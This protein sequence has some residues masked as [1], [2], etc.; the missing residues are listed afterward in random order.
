[1]VGTLFIVSTPIGNLEDITFRAIRT[2]KDASTIAAEDTR[3]T[4]KLCTHYGIGTPL[5]SYHDF[6][7]EEK[8]PVFLQRLQEG[9][10]IALVSDAGTPLISDPGFFLVREALAAKIP[11]VP[12]PGPSAVL[13]ALVAS[14]FPPDAFTFEGFV[15]RKS[16]ARLQLFKRLDNEG[17][18]TILF[19]TPHR[20]RSTLEVLQE[21]MGDRTLVV[22]RELTKLHEEILRGTAQEL[23][24]SKL[25]KG[26]KGEVTI[27]IEGKPGKKRKASQSQP[28]EC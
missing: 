10:H 5:T 15:P 4:K 25:T 27:V 24:E 26:V 1:M 19:E 14:G 28:S 3:R 18:T 23:L 20:L 9:E 2:L 11:V 13:A 21:T 8:T 17:R 6:N 16:G 12:I 22:A 7:K